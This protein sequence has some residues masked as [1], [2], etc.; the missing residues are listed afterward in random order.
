M[1]VGS[2]AMK[3]LLQAPEHVGIEPVGRGQSILGY[4]IQTIEVA[5]QVFRLAGAVLLAGFRQPVVVARVARDGGEQ[6]IVAQVGL[7]F[8]VEDLVQPC[9][10][11]GAFGHGGLQVRGTAAKWA[12]DGPTD[13]LDGETSGF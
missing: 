3:V 13:R 9:R 7:P 1:K 11:I 4:P 12:E 5:P 6:R 2:S 8:V 10:W